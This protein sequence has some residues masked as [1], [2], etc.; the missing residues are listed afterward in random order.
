LNKKV[1]RLARRTAL[2]QVIHE[3]RLTVVEDFSFEAP[4]TKSFISFLNSFNASNEKVL[5][6]TGDKSTNV[7]L[8][9]R[10]LPQANIMPASELNTYEVLDARRVFIVESGV[11]TVQNLISY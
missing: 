6:L 2:S 4:K 8:S 9:G 11:E 7:F 3:G 5:L 1:K 10:N